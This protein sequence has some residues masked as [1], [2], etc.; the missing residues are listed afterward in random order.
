MIQCSI[1]FWAD[2][3]QSKDWSI[4]SM[5]CQRPT[6]LFTI[7]LISLEIGCWGLKK[8]PVS[9]LVVCD[10]SFHLVLNNFVWQEHPFNP[11]NLRTWETESGR[12]EKKQQKKEVKK[13]N[14]NRKLFRLKKSWGPSSERKRSDSLSDGEHYFGPSVRLCRI[15]TTY[16]TS[17]DIFRLCIYV[18][19]DADSRMHPSLEFLSHLK[20]QNSTVRGRMTVSYL[21][22]FT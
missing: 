17:P 20:G 12:G 16:G 18:H 13:Q 6:Y 1:I 4:Y 10:I 5:F 21:L 8:M 11:S 3:W 14:N 2:N 15:K 9:P 7:D 19:W 22:S